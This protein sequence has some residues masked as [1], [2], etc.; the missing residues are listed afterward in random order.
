MADTWHE[1]EIKATSKDGSSHTIHAEYAATG[2]T[3]QEAAAEVLKHVIQ[4][5]GASRARVVEADR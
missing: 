3:P 5:R 2:A 1:I 4:Q